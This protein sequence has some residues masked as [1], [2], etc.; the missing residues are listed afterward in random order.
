MIVVFIGAERTRRQP[1][2]KVAFCFYKAMDW[3]KHKWGILKYNKR[4]LF[5]IV[6]AVAV[7]VFI[8]I[9]SISNDFVKQQEISKDTTP[10]SVEMSNDGEVAGVSDDAS[11]KLTPTPTPFAA[12]KVVPTATLNP[13]STPASSNTNSQPPSNNNQSSNN[14]SNNS[15][16]QTSSPT[17]APTLIPTQEPTPTPDNTPFE[18][19]WTVSWSGDQVT[20]VVT[21]NKSLK[22]CQ[23]ERWGG[24]IG[25]SGGGSISGNTCTASNNASGSTPS[26]KFW[27]K[28]E[29]MNGETKEFGD[30]PNQGNAQ[31]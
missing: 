25:A 7:L 24:S 18:A 28:V 12:R 10:T 14:S 8:A 2:F 19:S 15:T 29:S 13:T 1:V 17:P 26:T 30:A 4:I 3:I 22:N 9:A 27:M 6:S 11:L 20:G 21:A 23:F 5:P 31:I 16:N